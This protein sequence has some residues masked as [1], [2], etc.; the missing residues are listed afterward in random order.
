MSKT[1][2]IDSIICFSVVEI[3]DSGDEGASSAKKSKKHLKPG[4]GNYVSFSNTIEMRQIL[5]ARHVTVIFMT[6]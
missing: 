6:K 3:T 2:F 1:V 4:K 5:I